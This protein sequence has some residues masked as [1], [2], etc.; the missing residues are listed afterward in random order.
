MRRGAPGLSRPGGAGHSPA[1]VASIP[2]WTAGS[3]WWRRC[4]PRPTAPPGAACWWTVPVCRCRAV[5]LNLAAR[6]TRAHRSAAPPHRS[7]RPGSSSWSLCAEAS[8]SLAL[9]GDSERPSPPRGGMCTR[10]SQGHAFVVVDGLLTLRPG[11][12]RVPVL[13]GQTPSARDECA[14]GTPPDRGLLWVS[15]ALP[16]PCTALQP[17]GRG[18]R[19]SA[20]GPGQ[21]CPEEGRQSRPHQAARLWRAG[22]RPLQEPANSS[23]RCWSFDSAKQGGKTHRAGRGFP[24]RR[25]AR[26]AHHGASVPPPC[27]PCSGG[28]GPSRGF[29][30]F[31][32][33]EWSNSKSLPAALERPKVPVAHQDPVFR[34]P[35]SDSRSQ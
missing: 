22:H 3:P 9:Q 34:E 20:H 7:N 35:D 24:M 32:P 21:A 14:G 29:P 15:E 16:G 30:S 28:T 31:L 19:G 13:L 26:F 11:G 23:G 27:P 10:P 33:G 4:R 2:F 8:L 18:R 6:A 5:P 25:E 1:A 12:G 17:P